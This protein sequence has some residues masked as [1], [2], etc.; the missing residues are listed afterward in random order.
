[1][2]LK[3]SSAFLR[4]FASCNPFLKTSFIHTPTVNHS[5][6]LDCFSSTVRLFLFMSLF[7][8]LS[9][10]HRLVVLALSLWARVQRVTIE[11][12]T[13]LS[14]RRESQYFNASVDL[15]TDFGALACDRLSRLSNYRC[16]IV[17]GVYQK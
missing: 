2:K 3:L 4:F 17:R 13:T 15:A 6:P 16:F 1:M 5:F 11:G 10:R 7:R 8:S 9:V 12:Q 14:F